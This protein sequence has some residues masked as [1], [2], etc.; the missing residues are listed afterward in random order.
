[1]R[2]LILCFLLLGTSV[3]CCAQR[4]IVVSDGGQVVTVTSVDTKCVFT[5]LFSMDPVRVTCF[6]AGVETLDLKLLVLAEETVTGQDT[7]HTGNFI[8]WN[9]QHPLANIFT[10]IININGEIHTGTF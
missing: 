2:N 3:L 9:F 10:Y 7:T 6:T 1:M 5:K 4:S 8:A